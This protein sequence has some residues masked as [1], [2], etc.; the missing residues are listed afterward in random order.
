MD[1]PIQYQIRCEKDGASVKASYD[2]QVPVG[3]P[4]LIASFSLSVDGKQL[5]DQTHWIPG[6]VRFN[7][8]QFTKLDHP[9]KDVAAAFSISSNEGWTAADTDILRGDQPFD[10]VSFRNS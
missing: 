9:D 4:A 1:T 5:I 3:G 6:Q 10:E 2:L 8:T 7:G